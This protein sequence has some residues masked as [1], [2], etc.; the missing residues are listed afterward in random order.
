MIVKILPIIANRIENYKDDNESKFKIELVSKIV[1]KKLT[2]SCNYTQEC[3]I[4]PDY[5]YA[6]DN[7]Y[8]DDENEEK[9][10]EDQKKNQENEDKKKE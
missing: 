8:E 10:S 9:T 3:A 2:L 4:E 1:T 7:I 6:D 5:L